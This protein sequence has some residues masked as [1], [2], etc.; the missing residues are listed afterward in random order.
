MGL[1]SRRRQEILPPNIIQMME[2]LGRH[3]LDTAASRE[4]PTAIWAQ[5]LQ[6]LV[7]AASGQPAAFVRALADTCVPVG[8]FTVYGADKAVVNLIG[9]HLQSDDWWRILDASLAFLRANLVP[10][11]RVARYAWRRFIETGGTTDTWI[12]LRRPP[13]REEAALHPVTEGEARRLLV[14]GREPDA[15]VVFVTREG[16]DYVAIIDAPRNSDDPRRVQDEW[17]R[18]PD[19]YDLYLE[20]GRSFQLWEWADPDIEPFMVTPRPLI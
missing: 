4:D 14:L 18:L 12:P 2:R 19:Q 5:T 15:N 16:G 10:P 20:A 6:P 17:K 11:M 13:S 1:F 7:P 3:E 8:G 9:H